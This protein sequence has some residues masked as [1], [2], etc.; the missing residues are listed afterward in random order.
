MGPH[1]SQEFSPALQTIF[2]VV[3]ESFPK[4]KM[5]IRPGRWLKVYYLELGSLGSSPSSTGPQ[6]EVALRTVSKTAPT[7]PLVWISDP[8]K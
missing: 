2:L 8:L 6:A 3:K 1:A 4:S 7:Q 5:K